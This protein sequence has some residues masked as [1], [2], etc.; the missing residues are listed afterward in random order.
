M[1]RFPLGLI[2][3]SALISGCAKIPPVDDDSVNCNLAQRIGNRAKWREGCCPDAQATIFIEKA[4]ANEL[5]VDTAIQI[6]ILNN[7]RVQAIFEEL[8]IARA[9]LIEAGLLS[10]PSWELEVRYPNVKGL[11]TNIEYLLTTNLLDIFLI[12]LRSKLARTELA[13]TTLRV[14]NE[15]LDLAFAVRETYYQL[16]AEQRKIQHIQASVELAS[17]M[18]E[19]ASKQQTIGNINSYQFQLTQARQLEAKL[20][21]LHSQNEVIRL[22]EK[23]YRLLGFSEEVSLRLPEDLPD[24]DYL[25][26][27]QSSL[28]A[29]ALA[30]RLDVQVAQYEVARLSQMVGLK[31]WWTYTALKGGLSG[32]REPDGINLTGPGFTGEI[33][34]FNYGQAARL[35]LHAQLRQAQDKLCALE[36]EV[37]SEVRE[38]HKL[39]MSYLKIIQ[40]YQRHLLPLQKQISASSE[41]LYNVMGLGLDNLLEQ[42]RQEVVAEQNFTESIKKY[43]VARVQL[44][45]ALGG[46]LF[47]LL[48]ARNE[49]GEEG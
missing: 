4:I 2:I 39:L 16:V 9:A 46:Y 36:L 48:P 43:L 17:I 18:S 13:Q 31:D 15:I 37:L 28:E 44:D 1:H 20:Q 30:H 40:D 32:K 29:V 34:I 19:L 23:F 41:Q 26:F 33:P 6:A 21:L 47:M 45:R 24:I 27:N 10:N 22:K 42:K 38:A 11:K 8:G 7:P 35:R 25:G 49:Q 3:T 12:P 5:L 14:S